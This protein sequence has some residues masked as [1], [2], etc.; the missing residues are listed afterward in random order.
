[1]TTQTL[2][3]DAENPELLR[4]DS[5]GRI[6]LARFTGPGCNYLGHKEDD[7]TIILRPAVVMTAREFRALAAPAAAATPSEPVA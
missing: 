5:R 7:G 1:M 3:P 4:V 6:N 2:S